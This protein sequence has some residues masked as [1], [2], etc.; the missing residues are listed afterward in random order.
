MDPCWYVVGRRRSDIAFMVI[1]GGGA[2][3]DVRAGSTVKTE[4]GAGVGDSEARIRS[5]YPGLEVEPHKYVEGHYLIVRPPAAV[6]SN[7]RI[8][9][10]T[11]GKRVTSY[12][13]GRM[14]EVRWIEGCS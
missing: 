4:A 5:L 12:R 11:D 2:G 7:Y 13:A 9:F 14:P 3:G 6:D 10:E 1:E 8:I